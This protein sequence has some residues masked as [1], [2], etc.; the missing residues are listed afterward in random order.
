VTA[1][2]Q[3]SAHPTTSLESP[4]SRLVPT[5]HLK[6]RAREHTQSFG[7]RKLAPYLN[8]S[9]RSP[10]FS[11]RHFNLTPTTSHRIE[12]LPSTVQPSTACSDPSTPRPLILLVSAAVSV[13]LV[14]RYR[15]KN[16]E[17]FLGGT[18]VTLLC[19]IHQ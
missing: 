16:S 5:A 13:R 1:L 6:I 9:L 12:P 11:K 17:Y 4:P 15:S 3:L 14:F 10:Y 2:R 19:V 7:P 18:S 8:Y